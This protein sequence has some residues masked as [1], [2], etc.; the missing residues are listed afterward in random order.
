MGAN[1]CVASR[2]HELSRRRDRQFSTH[3]NVRHSP[4]WSFQWNNRT[5]IEDTEGNLARFSHGNSRNVEFQSKSNVE[6]ESR[7]IS[8]GNDSF[9]SPNW[10]KPTTN[11]GTTVNSDGCKTGS[12]CFSSF[13]LSFPNCLTWYGKIVVLI[14][15]RFRISG[16]HFFKKTNFPSRDCG[17]FNFACEEKYHLISSCYSLFPFL[18]CSWMPEA[19]INILTSVISPL[20]WVQNSLLWSSS[21]MAWR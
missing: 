19:I 15:W 2:H 18:T 7:D 1:C 21:H 12:K 9:S 20:T 3:R 17:Y 11:S 13:F 16:W 14:N 4:L 6:M 5:R 10:Q 8:E